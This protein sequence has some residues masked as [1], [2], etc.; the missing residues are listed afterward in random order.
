MH[1]ECSCVPRH[2]GVINHADIGR[3]SLLMSCY[4][5]KMEY[6]LISYFIM[7]LLGMKAS[8]TMV[9][10]LLGYLVLMLHHL[11]SSPRGT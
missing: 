11:I 5:C 7:A 4:S 3:K 2:V 6:L 8:N 1:Y 9:A 10:L